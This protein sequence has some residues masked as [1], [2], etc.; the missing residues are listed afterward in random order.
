MADMAQSHLNTRGGGMC[1]AGVRSHAI[2]FN[3]ANTNICK[4][5]LHGNHSH[6]LI[7]LI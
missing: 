2:L 7:D 5:T 6:R 4:W 3:K 1:S